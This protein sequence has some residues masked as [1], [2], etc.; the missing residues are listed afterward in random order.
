MRI[1][2]LKKILY[3]FITISLIIIIWELYASYRNEPTIFPHT[4]QIIKSFYKLF[5]S[6]N[7]KT[8][9]MT[10]LRITISVT[11]AFI[12]SLFVGLLYIWKKDTLYFFKPIISMMK[13]IPLAVISIFLWLIF[14]STTAPYIITTLIIIPISIEGV[15]TSIDGIDKVLIEDLKM[16][17]TNMF[18]SL[19]YVYIPLIKDYLLMVFLQIFGLGLKVMVMGEYICQTKNSIGKILSV[20]KSGVGYQDAMSELVAWGILLVVLVVIIEVLIKLII[21]KIQNQNNKKTN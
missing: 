1:S 13:T 7:L 15:I 17:N 18:K 3:P 5:N 20:V 21:K 6:T 2:T 8:I 10:L 16:I 9:G 11:L 4:I 19:I 14:K 12:A